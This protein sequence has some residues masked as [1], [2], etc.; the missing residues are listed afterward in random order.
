MGIPFFFSNIIKKYGADNL[1]VDIL[2]YREVH[3]FYLDFNCGIHPAVR[4]CKSNDHDILIDAVIEYLTYLITII[5]PT[6]LLYIAIDGV[7]PMAKMKQQRL[8][9]FKSIDDNSIDS[10]DHDRCDYNMI[11]PGTVFMDR[12]SKKIQIF[13]NDITN[14]NTNSALKIILSDS[15]E[16]GEGEH[17]ILNHIKN[18]TNININNN[19]IVYGL[20]SDLILLMLSQ[21][22]YNKNIC[23]L[24]EEIITQNTQNTQKLK[25]DH[26]RMVYFLVE[27]FLQNI[28][29]SIDFHDFSIKDY[30]FMTF[31]VGNDFLPA[32]ESLKIKDSGFDIL[33]NSYKKNNQNKRLIS[34]TN[35]INFI[36]LKKIFQDIAKIEHNKTEQLF[37]KKINKNNISR[38]YNA[39][40]FNMKLYQNKSDE[41]KL[42]NIC[43]SYIKALCWNIQYYI[44]ECPDWT[45]FYK[46]DA[47]PLLTDIITFLDTYNTTNNEINETFYNTTNTITTNMQLNIILPKQSRFLLKNSNINFYDNIW[48]PDKF[49]YETLGKNKDWL[50]IPKIPIRSIISTESL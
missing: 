23:L 10:G 3:D 5:N 44:N 46:Y 41:I 6:K 40:Y 24:R 36:F 48:F 39:H 49:T 13:I 28:K 21:I 34:E 12:L 19:I 18:P 37:N 45:F 20:D 42:H 7:C 14:T 4:V 29:K 8:R 47:A 35:A 9:R 11:S 30:I 38:I 50:Y 25:N 27:S 16:R 33:F 22:N 32:I 31:F 2:P 17:K 15:N 43:S 1:V 26:P